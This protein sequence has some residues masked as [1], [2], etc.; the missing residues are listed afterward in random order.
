M[1]PFNKARRY[2]VNA[3]LEDMRHAAECIERY[4]GGLTREQ[5]LQNIEKQDAVVRRIEI[6]GEAA[7]RLMKADNNY[8]TNFPGLPLRDIKD[9]RNLV[10]HGYDAVDADIVWNTIKSDIRSLRLQLTSLLEQRAGNGL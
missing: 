1:T 7:D 5:F 4:T 3:C 10:I 8:A 6:L 9:M 2:D